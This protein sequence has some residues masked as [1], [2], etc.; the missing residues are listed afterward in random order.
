M[1][2]VVLIIAYTKFKSE[3]IPVFDFLFLFLFAIFSLYLL[4]EVND[5]F[6]IYLIVELQSLCFY[7]IISLRRYSNLSIEAA[8]K[9]FIFNMVV[10][11]CFLFLL[12]LVYGYLGT[13]NLYEI[14][15]LINSLSLINKNH[16]VF[17]SFVFVY[18]FFKLA[19][20]PFH[21]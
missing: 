17:F 18:I 1:G 7:I 13:L 8:V 9:Y 4:I 2:I 10:S 14:E 21:F 12:S 16:L 19:L 5:L 15:R 20:I 6:Y 11:V 3:S